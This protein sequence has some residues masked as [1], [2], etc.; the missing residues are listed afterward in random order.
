MKYDFDRQYNRIGTQA[1]K[2]E[3]SNEKRGLVHLEPTDMCAGEGGV[4]PMWIADMDFPCPQPVV[5]ALV[6]RAKHGFYG[7]TDTPDSYYTSIVSWMKRRYG[8]EVEPEWICTTPG[9]VPA[10]NLLVRTFVPPGAKTLI[11]PPVYYPFFSAIQNNEAEIAT[12]ALVLEERQY[13]MDFNDLAETLRDPQ[14]KMAILCNPHNPVGRVWT[15]K[16]L[17]RFGEMCLENNVLI[18]SDEIYADLIYRGNTFTPFA[19]LDEAFTQQAIICTAPS[20]T[21][22]LA[23]LQTSNMIIPNPDLR[24]R[25]LKILEKNGLFGI[26]VFGGVA[27]E[28]AYRY[29]EDWLEQVL[30]YLEGNLHCLENYLDRQI[31]G[32]RLIPPEG[33]YL[34]WLDCRSLGLDQPE[35]MQLMLKDARVHLEDGTVFGRE[36][37]GF[38]RMNIAC[39]RSMLIEVLERIRGAIE[40][41]QLA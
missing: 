10:L 5:E 29:G 1:I 32:I 36:G 38:L 11:Q 17:L 4:V 9:V 23:G 26:G 27:L 16:E 39:P 35:L 34:A 7:Y 6:T 37:D 31:P 8:W 22:N 14:V 40:R 24:L 18:V 33:T 30:E 25:F 15:R 19:I 13:R 2:W 41:R 21:F 20:K 12:S 28:A 3:F